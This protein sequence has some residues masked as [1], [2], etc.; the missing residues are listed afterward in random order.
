MTKPLDAV[1]DMSD[2]VQT[3][4]AKCYHMF[5]EKFVHVQILPSTIQHDHKRC[6]NGKNIVNQFKQC[7]SSFG[8]GSKLPWLKSKQPG[9]NRIYE[10]NYYRHHVDT[11]LYVP[12]ALVIY[13]FFFARMYECFSIHFILFSP[14]T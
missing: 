2:H 4:R 5:D 1:S 9:N 8:R 3:E 11:S 7:F 10:M 6:Q 12:M 13:I 14:R